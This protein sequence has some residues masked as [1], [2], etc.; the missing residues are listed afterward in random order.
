MDDLRSGVTREY[1]IA[2]WQKVMESKGLPPISYE[3]AREALGVLRAEPV[4]REPGV[5]G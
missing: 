4:E 1:A 5:E 3:F 2:H